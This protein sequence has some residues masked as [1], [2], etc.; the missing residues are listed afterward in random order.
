ALET[1]TLSAPKV[2]LVANVSVTS[3]S[4]PAAIKQSLVEQVTGR[5]RWRET[6]SGFAAAGIS[7]A[8]EVGAGR[9]L[10]GLLKRIDKSVEGVAINGPDDVHAFMTKAAA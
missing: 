9:V 4:D 6:A 8:L 7:T 3:L 10:T 2:P 1:V 5:V